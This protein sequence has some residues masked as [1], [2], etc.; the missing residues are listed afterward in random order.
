MSSYNVFADALVVFPYSRYLHFIVLQSTIHNN[1]AWNYCTTM[2]SDLNYTPGN[3]FETFPFP[4]NLTLDQETNLDRIGEDYHEHRRR[5]MLAMRLGLTKTYNLFHSPKLAL[6]APDEL[7]LDDKS[8]ARCFGKD[9]LML[10]NHLAKI[11]DACDFNDAVA[12]IQQL[13]ALHVEMD[14]A[15]LGAYGWTDINPRHDFYDVDYLPENDRVRFTIHP[16]ARRV[17]LER[18]LELNFQL[19]SE[20]LNAGLWAGKSS[21]RDGKKRAVPDPA[22][23]A[24]LSLDMP[25]PSS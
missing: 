17:I 13:R 23:G 25:L 19:H 20:E 12:A 21:P 4:Q 8:F 3:T 5:L 9:A 24:Q 2:K 11:P 16:D 7:A 6:A 14:R 15:V 1:W 22:S 10:R 18:L